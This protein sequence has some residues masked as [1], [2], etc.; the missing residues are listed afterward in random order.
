M[1]MSKRKRGSYRVGASYKRSR[2]T[3]YSKGSLVA[4]AKRARFGAAPGYR[5]S[6]YG[7]RRSGNVKFVDLASATYEIISTPGIVHIPII[8]QGAGESERIGRQVSLKSLQIH[9]RLYNG[10]TATI[11]NITMSIVYDR[12]PNKALAGWTDIYDSNSAN[13]FKK[14]E[15]KDRFQIIKEWRLV[16]TGSQVT[17]NVGFGRPLEKYIKL[18]GLP[19]SYSTAGTGAIGDINTG[20]L[21]FCAIGSSATGTTSCSFQGGFRVRYVDV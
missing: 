12:Q 7:A 17:T 2:G 9:G 3:R 8:A 19:V 21:L 20:A 10:T 6:G 16:V 11:N 5:K 13:S 4:A 15:N 14:D 1:G 18:K